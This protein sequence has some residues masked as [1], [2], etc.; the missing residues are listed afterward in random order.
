TVTRAIAPPLAS[1][2]VVRERVHQHAHRPAEPE[3][4]GRALAEQQHPPRADARLDQ[5]EL[6]AEVL[7]RLLA[8]EARHASARDEAPDLGAAAVQLEAVAP[9]R[10]QRDARRQAERQRMVG[11]ELDLEEGARHLLER[12]L[13]LVLRRLA[14]HLLLLRLLLL[15]LL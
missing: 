4:E 8:R 11:V 15:L 13:A 10:E 12:R 3:A 9:G 7:R 2:A 14:P 6:P 1:A 5:P